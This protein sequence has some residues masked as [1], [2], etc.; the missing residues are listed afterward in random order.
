MS[1]LSARWASC[2][3]ENTDG[4]TYTDMV[5]AAVMTGQKFACEADRVDDVDTRR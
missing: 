3:V 1:G 4:Q 5:Q 2:Y